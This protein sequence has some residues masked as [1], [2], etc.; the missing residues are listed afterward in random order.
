MLPTL[1]SGD[2]VIINRLSYIIQQPK[3]KDIIVVKSPIDGRV[4]IKRIAEIK[5][6]NIFVLG[7]NSRK[8]TDSRKFG[9]LERS[10]IIGKVIYP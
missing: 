9:M 8:S 1:H 7:D 6:G 3:V 10:A 5:N 4:I 2:R